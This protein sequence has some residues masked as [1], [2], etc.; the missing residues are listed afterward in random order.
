MYYQD[1]SNIDQVDEINSSA[2]SSSS[3][4]H[5]PIESASSSTP[6]P[7]EQNDISKRSI[8]QINNPL[9]P[10][11]EN[12]LD[13][14][15]SN[16]KKLRWYDP[17]ER[18]RLEWGLP[19]STTPTMETAATTTAK[20][21][22]E[23][24][25]KIS[26]PRRDS[27]KF[28]RLYNRRSSS[29]SSSSSDQTIRYKYEL[30]LAKTAKL[31]DEQNNQDC[32]RS[33][34]PS[35]SRSSKE[36]IHHHHQESTSYRRSPTPE[37][38]HNND[39]NKNENENENNHNNNNNNTNNDYLFEYYPT[40][41][42][43]N[44]RRYG[45]ANPSYN[46]VSRTIFTKDTNYDYE[47]EQGRR[48]SIFERIGR[49]SPNRGDRRR[50]TNRDDE[51]IPQN[52]SNDSTNPV[53]QYR[54]RSRS[55]VRRSQYIP[56]RECGDHIVLNRDG[57]VNTEG[58][59][60]PERASVN[61]VDQRLKPM[62]KLKP[63][64]HPTTMLPKVNTP[65]TQMAST[66]PTT[67]TT[68]TQSTSASTS[69]EPSEPSESLPSSSSAIPIIQRSQKGRGLP[70]FTYSSQGRRIPPPST[71]SSSI[72]VDQSMM[73]KN[74]MENP[75][76]YNIRCHQGQTSYQRGQ[77][78]KIIL[79]DS[80]YDSLR[81]PKNDD[82]LDISIASNVESLAIND[83]LEEISKELLKNIGKAV[84]ND[85]DNVDL[86]ANV[87]RQ[88]D[89][90]QQNVDNVEK[91]VDE[92]VDDNIIDSS[93]K[94]TIV[95]RKV[96]KYLNNVAC[97]KEYFSRFGKVLN[98]KIGYGRDQHAA[99][100]KF[101]NAEEATDAIRC[102]DAVCNNRFIRVYRSA[103]KPWTNRR[104]QIYQ[105][106]QQQQQQWRQLQQ[107]RS[108]ESSDSDLSERGNRK[109]QRKSYHHHFPYRM[110]IDS[111]KE[112]KLDSMPTLQASIE[113]Q[114]E[115]Q[116]RINASIVSPVER[117]I[118]LRELT[119]KTQELNEAMANQKLLIR[120]FESV[121]TAKEK[122]AIMSLIQ[123]SMTNIKRIQEECSNIQA[124]I[125]PILETKKV[126]NQNEINQEEEEH[127]EEEEEAVE[128]EIFYESKKKGKK[129]RKTTKKKQQDEDDEE[130][131]RKAAQ[132]ILTSI[133]ERKYLKSKS[134]K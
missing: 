15:E 44:Q 36:S 48:R 76:G 57:T 132:E 86:P 100:I 119:S 2:S 79:D 35:S 63:F 24:E 43:L 82:P 31:N 93:N 120:K 70:S 11:E 71:S 56:Y 34:S 87:S 68:T 90:Q 113:K 65:P 6:Q 115:K 40:N 9:E 105:Q 98:V 3:S 75:I 129:G 17:L 123:N 38:C 22:C 67:T 111:P 59:V 124:F 61:D 1:R 134:S 80:F 114:L 23:E 20:E 95:L 106:K 131:T 128:E 84:M 47:L 103:F 104:R 53:Q 69:H 39:N 16:N 117:Q 133:C 25:R 46:P 121:K 41:S 72:L 13:T 74:S 97:L 27:G 116:C 99:I 92:I 14:W 21:E 118:K 45:N 83:P 28:Y 110:E 54:N 33:K 89:E 5:Q 107:Q 12:Q 73:G 55:P 7:D 122:K 18:F 29:E 30:F 49:Y 58:I 77:T 60:F 50:N 32:E 37:H 66:Q 96:P 108:D 42:R 94:H 91:V 130:S 88:N 125:K 8:S 4:Q 62:I 126:Y 109:T 81:E 52:I 10:Q 64:Q 78:K 102:S 85:V 26:S 112:E 127:S 19:T 51:Y 101:S